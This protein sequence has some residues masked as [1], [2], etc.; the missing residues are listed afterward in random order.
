ML[1]YW[2]KTNLFI[3]PLTKK[4]CGI[5]TMLYLPDTLKMR[6]ERQYPNLSGIT[7]PCCNLDKRKRIY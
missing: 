6:L 3:A 1:D 2:K 5:A 7:S 4:V